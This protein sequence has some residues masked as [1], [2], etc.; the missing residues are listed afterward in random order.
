MQNKIGD[1]RARR[2]F[3]RDVEVVVS[4]SSSVILDYLSGLRFA[5]I[6]I[7]AFFKFTAHGKILSLDVL[8][9]CV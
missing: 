5:M 1:L 4:K 7:D 3:E 2:L 8:Y 6:K 9:F